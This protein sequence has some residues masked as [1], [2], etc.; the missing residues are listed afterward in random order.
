MCPTCSNDGK[1]RYKTFFMSTA[2]TSFVRDRWTSKT[3]DVYEIVLLLN[4]VPP[5]Q[6]P[7]RADVI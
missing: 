2:G 6:R 7:A 1:A 5:P 3:L 4:A